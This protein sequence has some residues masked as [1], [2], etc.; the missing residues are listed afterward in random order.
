M[1][2]K[3]IALKKWFTSFAGVALG[4]CLAAP[5]ACGEAVYEKSPLRYWERPVRNVVTEWERAVMRGEKIFDDSSEKAFLRDVLAAMDVPVESQVLVF[6]KTSFQ[7][8]TIDPKSPRA[9]YFSDQHYVGWVPGGEIEIATVDRRVGFT[10]YRIAMPSYPGG[11]PDIVR[12]RGCLFCHAGRDD[13]PY[14]GLMLLSTPTAPDGTQ[15]SHRGEVLA[16]DYRTPVEDRWAGWY[17]TGQWEGARHRGN[18]LLDPSPELGHALTDS[19][20]DFGPAVGDLKE[21]F[22][23]PRYLTGT[24][25]VVALLVLEHQAAAHNRIL[26]ASGN[27]RIALY[28]D[29]S[30]MNGGEINEATQAV[31]AEET[32]RLLEVL[33]FKDEASLAGVEVGGKS[34]FRPVFESRGVEG[35]EGRSLRDLQL[36]DRLFEYRCSYMIHSQAF[37]DMPKRFRQHVLSELRT[38]LEQ[39]AVDGPYAYIPDEERAEILEI[40]DSAGVWEDEDLAASEVSAASGV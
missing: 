27:A 38:I 15:L 29:E 3:G 21:A 11:A 7:V 12:D 8:K 10:F 25:D 14:P 35:P 16:I 24:S 5:V 9:L 34:P 36:D 6:S 2:L 26:Q 4:G 28:R 37:A 19:D 22:Y 17:V 1:I 13:N 23:L 33:L 40:L 30:Y 18:L 32:E 20:V 31:F 39:P